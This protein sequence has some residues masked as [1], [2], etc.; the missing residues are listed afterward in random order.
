MQEVEGICQAAEEL[1]SSCR[2]AV[3]LLKACRIPQGEIDH[4]QGALDQYYKVKKRK[5]QYLPVKCE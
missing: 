5:R 2:R 3:M 4:L 1:A